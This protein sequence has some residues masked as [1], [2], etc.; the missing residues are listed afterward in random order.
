MSIYIIEV[1]DAPTIAEDFVI[2]KCEHI[3]MMM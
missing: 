2:G 3:I 1:L